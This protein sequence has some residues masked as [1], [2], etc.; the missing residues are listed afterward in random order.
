M[1]RRLQ[2]A[3]PFLRVRT[4]DGPGAAVQIADCDATAHNVKG[5]GAPQIAAYCSYQDALVIKGITRFWLLSFLVSVSTSA[6]KFR[7]RLTRPSGNRDVQQELLH[8]GCS[9]TSTRE[10]MFNRARNGARNN[11]ANQNGEA[12]RSRSRSPAMDP[13]LVE[14][15]NFGFQRGSGA[16]RLGV[17]QFAETLQAHTNSISLDEEPPLQE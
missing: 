1:E 2:K 15:D 5:S 11:P 17:A 12:S 8:S 14:A 6:L 3:T 13:I 7:S 10:K 4:A 16:N 9:F